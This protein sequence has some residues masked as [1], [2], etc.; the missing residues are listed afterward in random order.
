MN[1][2]IDISSTNVSV[3]S[4]STCM[5]SQNDLDCANELCFIAE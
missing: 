1:L 5:I 3:S 4:L 2:C